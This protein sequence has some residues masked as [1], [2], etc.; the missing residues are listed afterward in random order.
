LM[1]AVKV[2]EIM[3]R[4]LVT[5]AENESLAAAAQKMLQ[6]KTSSVLVLSNGKPVGIVTEKDFV[7][8]FAFGVPYDEPLKNHMSRNLITVDEDT[9]INDARNIL[10]THRIRHLPVV[11]KRGEAVGMVTVRDILE[12]VQTL[13]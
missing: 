10:V 5:A 11:N 3:S 2:K 12:T 6:S 8:F 13:F 9:S 1:Q 4:K 7:K